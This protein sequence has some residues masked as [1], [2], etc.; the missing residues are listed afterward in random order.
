MLTR[1]SL[2]RGVF[3]LDGVK[4]V[5]NSSLAT[6]TTE[7]QAWLK[8]A[9]TPG[10]N[11]ARV[12]KLLE[13]FSC[14]E[15]VCAASQASLTRLGFLPE[16]TRLALTH[17]N[18]ADIELSLAW[19]ENPQQHFIPQNH[20]DYP[21]QLRNIP[22]PPLGLFV[23]GDLRLLQ[24]PQIAI[25]GSR[26]PDRYGREHAQRFAFALA[27]C[28]INV[29]SGMALGIDA[30]AHQGAL[31]A[32]GDTIAVLGSGLQRIY[33][34]RHQALAE[35]I[36]QHGCLLS[37][38]PLTSP[39]RA[40]QFPRRNRIISGLSL[41]CLVIQAALRS[42]SLITARLALEQGREVFALPGSIDNPLSK[43]CHHLLRQG[44]KLLESIEEILIEL[45]P[46][47]RA[48]IETANQFTI[49][50]NNGIMAL[51]GQQF[52][53][54]CNLSLDHSIEQDCVTSKSGQPEGDFSR[55]KASG[56]AKAISPT[57]QKSAT[58]DN[59]QELILNCLKHESA[60]IDTLVICCELSTNIVS[61][62]LQELELSGLVTFHGG[63][64]RRI[65]RR[66]NPNER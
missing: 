41:A 37:E 63:R 12:Q 1:H 34:Q 4:K 47:L 5:T 65:Q 7:L 59:L 6:T 64:Y 29:C 32:G 42:G 19:L 50:K 54:D 22:D 57:K 8:L 27:E 18:Q 43:G 36:S 66:R 17:P 9:H 58:Q 62:V 46:Q 40:Q 33:P 3:L 14:V 35:Q 21:N 38:L 2:W 61:S 60:T 16:K 44:A 48:Y 26:N 20:P 13:I 45:E 15:A 10:L 24:Q 28:G 51:S 30:D 49:R 11:H 55:A 56:H 23:Q 39:P 53:T 52:A 31:N 25:V